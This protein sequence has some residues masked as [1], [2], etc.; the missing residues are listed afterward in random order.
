MQIFFGEILTIKKAV[1]S[2]QITLFD[3][4][5]QLMGKFK[6]DEGM[7]Y[8]SIT[9]LAYGKYFYKAQQL[10]KENN[11]IVETD[12]VEFVIRVPYYGKPFVCN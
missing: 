2:T 1:A 7:F 11:V 5:V 4:M 6:V 10:D 9:N 8:K 12:F 3:D